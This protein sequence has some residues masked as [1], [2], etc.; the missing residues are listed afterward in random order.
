MKLSRF[1]AKTGALLTWAFLISLFRASL[2]ADLPDDDRPLLTRAPFDLINSFGEAPKVLY[3]PWI[4]STNT[5]SIFFG[6]GENS[7]FDH[8][9]AGY[10]EPYLLAQSREHLPKQMYFSPLRQRLKRSQALLPRKEA[11]A[12]LMKLHFGA[13]FPS[14]GLWGGTAVWRSSHPDRVVVYFKSGAMNA[15]GGIDTEFKRIDAVV[16][17]TRDPSSGRFYQVAAVVP[18]SERA[19]IMQDLANSF[20][21]M[22]LDS[23]SGTEYSPS[24]QHRSQETV[25]LLR[26]AGPS[27]QVG[28][29][30]RQFVRATRSR[31]LQSLRVLSV[32]PR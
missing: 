2:G 15:S 9:E 27:I 3:V 5:H 13:E 30:E 26:E 22:A 10:P 28:S 19:S 7:V 29:S 1:V 6:I 24:H 31:C 17:L 12:Q 18:P 20:G 21:V 16:S 11:H 14:E 8:I 23:D 32:S 25:K 4:A